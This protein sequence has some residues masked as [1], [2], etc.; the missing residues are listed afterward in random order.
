MPVLGQQEK[1]DFA[2]SFMY[3]IREFLNILEE[4]LRCYKINWQWVN[5]RYASNGQKKKNSHI[6]TVVQQSY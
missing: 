3:K 1:F 6:E 4:L 2:V 5:N